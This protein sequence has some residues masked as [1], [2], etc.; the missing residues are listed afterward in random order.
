MAQVHLVGAGPGDPELL[1]VRAAR[2][3]E[4]A[5]CVYHDALVTPE[6]LALARPGAELVA[7]GHRS[8]QAKRDMRGY[9]AAMA[10]RARRGE[11]VV[12]L[13]GGDPFVFGRGGEEAVALLDAGVDFTV[14]P[15]VSSAV[16]GPAAAGIPVTHRDVARS[17][18]VVTG[19]EAE[20]TDPVRWARLATGA[21]TLVVL[22]GIARLSRI[23]AALIAAGRA[24]STPAA[25]V[26]DA[27]T[28]RQQTVYATLASVVD[29]A[30]AAGLETPALMVVGEVVDVA[31]SLRALPR[32]LLE[33][34]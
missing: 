19:H 27:T 32:E 31:A 6:V 24:P 20:G 25:V 9:V 30:G 29:A 14:T 34:G 8:G 26:A 2:L 11:V 5:D 13:K 33:A 12:R 18:T 28:P 22:M 21:D 3:L 1:T 4:R 7:I 16:A 17:F 10:A 23:C 15:G